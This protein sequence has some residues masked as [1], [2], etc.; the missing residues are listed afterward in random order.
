[1]VYIHGGAFIDGATFHHPPNYLLEKDIVL[2]VPQYRLGP[3]GF[4]STM[5]QEIPGNAAILDVILALQ[6]IQRNI[7][8]FGGDPNQITLFGQSA[9]AAI[10]SSLILTPAVPTSLFHKVIIQSGSSMSSWSVDTDPIGNARD[11]G[12][13]V[14][15]NQS[16]PIRAL[17][18]CFM[19][20]D[21]LTLLWGFTE[22]L[23]SI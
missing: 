12:R 19:A 7:E 10:V 22:H 13:A 3:L 5:T 20:V 14:G 2:V 18:E 11:I 17:N 23:V 4:L 8:H 16:E 21:V 15:C 1:M 9:G 6:W